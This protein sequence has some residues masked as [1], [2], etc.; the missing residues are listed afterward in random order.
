[1]LQPLQID[2]L[3]TPKSEEWKFT[4]LPR[5]LPANLVLAEEPQEV[6]IHKNRGQVCEQ[7]EDIL[8]TGV[9]K[10]HVRRCATNPRGKT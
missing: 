1:M 7:L 4:N 5:A 9:D 10:T 3:P 6:V 2:N 8:F